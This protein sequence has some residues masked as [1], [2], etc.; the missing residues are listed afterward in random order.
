MVDSSLVRYI[1]L[2]INNISAKLPQHK[3]T[4]IEEQIVPILQQVKPYK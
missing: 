2:F 4:F 1:L 3:E